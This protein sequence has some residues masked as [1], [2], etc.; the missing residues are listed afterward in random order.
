MKAS[1][2]FVE[3]QDLMLTGK[4]FKLERGTLAVEQTN[5]KRCAVTI[6][7]GEI[8]QVVAGP[9]NGDGLVNV[10]WGSRKVEMFAVDVD[11]RGTELTD[12][13]ANAQSS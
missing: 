6:S 13:A 5:G 11:V 1:I 8:I 10:L 3:K 9:N 2:I 12:L 4:R 7:T